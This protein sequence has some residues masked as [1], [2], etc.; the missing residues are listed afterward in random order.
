MTLFKRF[1]F[2][3]TFGENV[4]TFLFTLIKENVFTILFTCKHLFPRT[5]GKD[6]KTT[7]FITNSNKELIHFETVNI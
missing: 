3:F 7:V 5:Q 1:T 4:F 2:L 6:K